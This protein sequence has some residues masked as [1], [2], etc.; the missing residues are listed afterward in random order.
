[1]NIRPQE[2]RPTRDS[3]GMFTGEVH[4]APR[5]FSVRELRRI[6]TGIGVFIGTIGFF[7]FDARIP[8]ANNSIIDQWNAVLESAAVGVAFIAIASLL[9]ANSP[10]YK[11]RRK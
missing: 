1:M 6:I 5:M 10:N 8:Y 2:L 11:R 7:Y 4:F 3:R 9:I